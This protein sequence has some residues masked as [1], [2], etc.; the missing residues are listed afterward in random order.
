M[1]PGSLK[2]HVWRMFCFALLLVCIFGPKLAYKLV[3]ADAM[4]LC[5]GFSFTLVLT[6]LWLIPGLIIVTCVRVRQLLH[7][8]LT[9]RPLFLW[10]CG[11]VTLGWSQTEEWPRITWITRTGCGHPLK[12]AI[13]IFNVVII[14]QHQPVK[15]CFLRERCYFYSSIIISL[16]F[17]HFSELGDLL[18]HRVGSL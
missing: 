10:L 8:L 4:S 18:L 17:V 2:C 14:A 6:I 16:W 7:T 5:L 15:W 3:A 1:V 11:D 9:R 13:I 12:I